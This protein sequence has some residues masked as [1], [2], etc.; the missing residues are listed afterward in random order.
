ME[1]SGSILSENNLYSNIEFY[2]NT[3]ID[4]IH[5]DI[6]DGRFVP[7]T[8]ISKEELPKVISKCNKN[9]DVHLMVYNPKEYIEILKNY[10]I[11]Y[12]TIHYEIENCIDYIKMIK[13]NNIKVGISIKPM[14]KVNEI[15]ALLPFVD[16]VLVMSVNPG[17]SGQKFIKKT[18]DK[19]NRLKKEITRKCLNTKISVDG[20]INKDVLKYVKNADILVS[21]T[22]LLNNKDNINILKNYK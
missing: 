2:N 15:V 11:S 12:I 1:V 22:Y 3:D 13:E 14:T 4:Y 7:N 5:L 17:F 21:A 18:K 9:I 16:L 10:N 20:G 19:V 8:F 6:M